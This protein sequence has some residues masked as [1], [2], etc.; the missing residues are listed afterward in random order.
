MGLTWTHLE[1]LGF[2]T[3][4]DIHGFIWSHLDS[5][6]LGWAYLGS[7]GLIGLTRIYLGITWDSL[8]LTWTH[9]DAL[10]PTRTHW[11]IETKEITRI[12][13]IIRK[14]QG[15]ME[16]V[17]SQGKRERPARHKE[18]GK[19]PAHVLAEISPDLAHRAHAR[20]HARHE[21]ISLLRGACLKAISLPPTSDVYT[22]YIHITHNV[23]YA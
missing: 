9:L 11:I 17:V 13:E 7:L 12:L 20:T 1:P 10:G 18:K 5:L 19:V 14:Y 23:K 2:R 15:K 4:L 16:R 3:Q 21:T 22:L 8:G 6:G